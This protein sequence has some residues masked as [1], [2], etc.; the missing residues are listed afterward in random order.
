[1]HAW[2]KANPGRARPSSR[3]TRRAGLLE[4][5]GLGHDAPGS[6][7]APRG[8]AASGAGQD[9]PGLGERIKNKLHGH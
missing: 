2:A 1:M 4:A 5:K 7:G 6:S 3:L 8:A 9:K